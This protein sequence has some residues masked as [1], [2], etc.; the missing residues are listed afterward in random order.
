MRGIILISSCLQNEMLK[1][2]V[3]VEYCN[4]HSVL[5]L[6]HADMH[7]LMCLCSVVLFGKTIVNQ[8]CLQKYR[9]LLIFITLFESEPHA[10]I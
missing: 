2:L 6:L 1:I 5:A 9:M 3:A 7:C 10:D 8:L 4:V